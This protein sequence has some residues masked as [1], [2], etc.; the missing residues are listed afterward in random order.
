[1]NRR[2]VF[3]LI[4]AS[5]VVFCWY[6]AR[7][8]GAPQPVDPLLVAPLPEAPAW[9]A[10]PTLL[11]HINEPGAIYIVTGM[12]GPDGLFEALRLEV[13]S[14]ARSSAR[15]KFGPNTAFIPFDSA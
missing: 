6:A 4:M 10:Q 15:I 13:K 2:K 5:I 14:G 9:Q 11:Q 7:F 3:L 8:D 1:M 12:P